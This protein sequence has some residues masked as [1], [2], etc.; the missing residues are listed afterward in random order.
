M[1]HDETTH[2]A[3]PGD[4]SPSL[5]CGFTPH[6]LG[7]ASAHRANSQNSAAPCGAWRHRK[8]TAFHPTRDLK[9]DRDRDDRGLR[10]PEY[11]SDPRA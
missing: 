4:S 6:G 11:V 10:P 5:R 1:R 7:H 2:V 8:A 3:I 9:F